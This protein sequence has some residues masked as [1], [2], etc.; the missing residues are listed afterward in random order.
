MASDLSGKAPF[1]SLFD[2]HFLF[3][4]LKF[5]FKTNFSL[6]S[7]PVMQLFNKKQQQPIRA[8]VVGGGGGGGGVPVRKLSAT[9]THT[10]TLK[11]D[12]QFDNIWKKI[13]P[14]LTS[15]FETKETGDIHIC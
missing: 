8:L 3:S 15:I 12:Q 1:N 10:H 9:P 6:I 14:I 4:F 7:Q 5:D 13:K 11:L 2:S